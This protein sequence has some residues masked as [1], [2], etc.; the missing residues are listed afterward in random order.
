MGQYRIL[1][2]QSAFFYL[3]TAPTC[4]REHY[5]VE[6][7]GRW[8]GATG[9]SYG[10][11]FGLLPDFSQYYLFDV[12]TDFRAYRLLRRNPG[13]G[14]SVVAPIANSS[15]IQSGNGANRLKMTRNGDLITLAV[16]GSTLGTWTDGNIGGD[17]LVRLVV[18]A[19]YS[20]RPAADARFDDFSVA[21]VNSAVNASAGR[22]TAEPYVGDTA[23]VNQLLEPLM[24][25]W[26]ETGG[27]L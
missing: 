20:H 9:N 11:I 18:S 25:S 6:V 27:M 7:D 23:V 24:G 12:N 26:W 14:F 10:L 13:G 17:T 2:K 19:S 1:T 4:G 5:T 15:A 3:F 8:E 16:N 22:T 21:R